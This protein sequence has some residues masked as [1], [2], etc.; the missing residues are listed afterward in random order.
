M[1]NYFNLDSSKL[2]EFADNNFNFEEN[3][4]NFSK[5]VENTAKN[6][7]I[8]CYEQFLLFLKCFQK[9]LYNRHIKQ[10]LVWKRDNCGSYYRI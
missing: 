2:K 7:E 8:A 1:T 6:G 9:K 4:E 10:E 5:S 3:G